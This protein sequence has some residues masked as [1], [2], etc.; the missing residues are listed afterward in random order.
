MKRTTLFIV[1]MLA[2]YSAFPQENHWLTNYDDAVATAKKEGKNLL[3]SFSGSD[4]CNNCMRLEQ[5]LFEQQA[6]IDFAKQELVLLQLDFPARK[7]NKL[8]PAQTK[9]NEA[10]AERF[11]KKGAFPTVLMVNADGK[12]VGKMKHPGTLA[13]YMSHLKAL[14]Q[15]TEKTN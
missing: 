14:N 12:V 8:S 3:I 1:L 7:K 2:F 4:W 10:L 5:D 9:H 15:K 11:N 13:D 6:F